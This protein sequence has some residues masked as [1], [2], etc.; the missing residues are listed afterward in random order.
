MGLYLKSVRE[1]KKLS[2]DDVQEFTKIRKVYIQ[3]IE[4]GEFDRLPG[5]F[6]VRAFTKSYCEVLGLSFQDIATQYLDEL[7][8]HDPAES[9]EPSPTFRRNR[10]AN[11][12]RI[13]KWGS[14]LILIIGVSIVLAIVYLIIVHFNAKED[15][16]LDQSRITN[17]AKIYVS[18]SPSPS[19][20]PSMEP[21][22]SVSPVSSVQPSLAPSASPKI[23]GGNVTLVGTDSNSL[24]YNVEGV[25]AIQLVMQFNEDC[26]TLFRDQNNTGEIIKGTL[27]KS[28]YAAGDTET[29]NAS[30]NVNLRFGNMKGVKLTLNGTPLDDP[31]LSEEGARNIQIN[32]VS[33]NTE[34]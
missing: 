7:A 22:P 30:N 21:S 23:V 17:E 32:L 9:N 26:W 8:S 27:G 29:L 4:D 3:A 31:M 12:D 34:Q 13:A 20:S 5:A 24:V 28:T 14:S 19:P 16:T 6:Y 18:P 1:S 33:E 15:R 10:M 2:L 25:K 11:V